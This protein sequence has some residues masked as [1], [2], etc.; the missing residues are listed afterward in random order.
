MRTEDCLREL[1]RHRTDEVVIAAMTS[2][3]LWPTL[4][5]HPRDLIYV[6]STMGGAPGLGLGIA[7]A[8]PDL[9]VVVLNGDGSMLM[10]L[11]SLVTIGEQAPPNLLLIVFDNGLYAVTGGQVTPGAGRIDFAAMA[12]AAGWPGAHCFAELSAWAGAAPGL[13]AAR[14]PVFVQLKVDP[15]PGSISPPSVP[16]TE[17]LARLRAAVDG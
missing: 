15:A 12:A 16:M 6:P 1:A 14:G 13:L 8:R 10:N 17:R 3:V 5:G 7:M 9:H 4:S 2:A 11:G